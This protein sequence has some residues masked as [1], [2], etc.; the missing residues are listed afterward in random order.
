MTHTFDMMKYIYACAYVHTC[1]YVYTTHAYTQVDSYV[2]FVTAAASVAIVSILET[3]ISAKIACFRAIDN[4]RG[5]FNEVCNA[6]RCNI[7]QHTA[8]YCNALQDTAAQF[9]KRSPF[10]MD[11]QMRIHTH[12]HVNL[13]VHTL[14]HTLVHTYTSASWY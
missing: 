7:M 9:H 14:V 3:L 6:L 12:A 5:P 4:K 2:G 1:M 10:H 11:T 8:T 13:H